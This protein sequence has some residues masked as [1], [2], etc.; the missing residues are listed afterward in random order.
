MPKFTVRYYGK[1]KWNA[2]KFLKL[3][4][5]EESRVWI[6]ISSKSVWRKFHPTHI[7]WDPDPLHFTFNWRGAG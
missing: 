1:V 7:K 3:N 2:F 6:E 5:N 4:Y